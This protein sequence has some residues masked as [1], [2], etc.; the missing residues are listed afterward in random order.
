LP[1][2]IAFC[3][4]DFDD[5]G[6]ER[7]LAELVTRLPRD[8]FKPAVVVLSGPPLSPADQLL[9]QVSDRRIPVTFLEAR[10][11]WSTPTVWWKLRQWLR[12]FKPE[13]LQCYL[14]HANV[15]GALAAHYSGVNHVVTG[16]QVAELRRR[17]HGVLQLAVAR[18]AEKHVCVSRSVVD[19]AAKVMRLPREKL[20]IIPNGIEIERWAG[21]RPVARSRLGLDQ[22]RRMILFAGRL[23]PQ[24]RPDWLLERM[25]AVFDRLPDH[26]LVVA[27]EGP[28]RSSLGRLAT[29]LGISERIHFVGW[30]PDMPSL[31]AAA[32]AVVLTSRWEGM[33]NIVLEAMAA[34][35]PV[36]TTD[37]HGVRELLGNAAGIQIAPA[38]DAQAFV[39][40]VSQLCNDRALETLLGQQNQE[41][42]RAIF[43]MDA[44]VTAYSRLYESLLANETATPMIA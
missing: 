34:A 11:I 32:D 39:D 2:R 3:I 8:R 36:V 43:S 25:P 22:N 24:K 1:V 38:N 35:R 5:G 37:V 27:G 42:A 9:Q 31:L 40:A 16:I 12:D 26:D 44:M 30:Q 41:R 15:L 28:L 14:A 23:D 13:L 20:L 7:H 10:S 18:L 33:P 6:A 4:T 19:F 21:A 29:R 17:W